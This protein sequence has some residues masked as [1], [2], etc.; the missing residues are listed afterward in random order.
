[1]L[2]I[3]KFKAELEQFTGTAHYYHNPLYPHMNYTDG[4]KYLAVTVGA[5]WLLDIIGTEFFPKQKSGEW[6]SFVAIKLAVGV[7]SMT[8]SV[9]DGNHNEYLHKNIPF[10][11]FPEGE[12]ALWLVDGVLLLPSEY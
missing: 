7:R 6:D 2:E 9:Q 5:Y 12:W 10:T 3:A 4:V 11:D 1:M 8:I